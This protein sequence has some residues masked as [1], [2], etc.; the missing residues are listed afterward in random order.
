MPRVAEIA[1]AVS[2][3]GETMKSTSI[4]RSRHASRYAALVVRMIVCARLSRFT[5]IAEIRF[6]SSRGLQPTKRSA[7]STSALRTTSLLV[8]S[9]STVR[10]S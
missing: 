2:I 3:S 1:F 5:T 10:T 4:C 6:A 8:P 7:R 9:P